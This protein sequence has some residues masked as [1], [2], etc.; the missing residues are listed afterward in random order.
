[1]ETDNIE[2]IK[3]GGVG[4]IPT[5]TVYGLAC[6]AFNESAL[7]RM[8]EI[9]GRAENKPPVVLI[10]EMK[11]L[12]KFG[13]ELSDRAKILVT[14]FWPGPVSI[15][16]PIKKELAYLDKG[17]GLAIRLP[18]NSQLRD[19]LKKTGP[20]ATTSANLQGQPPA[21]NIEEARKYFG[22]RV[23]FYKEG[24]DLSQTASTLVKVKGDKVEILRQGTLRIDSNF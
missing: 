5:D 1:M 9:K 18:D 21:K 15:I 3:N 10:A 4:V 11:D 20:L 16:L 24:C 19:F 7:E 23:D 12:E 2:I 22:R 17:L 8:F 6:S 14:K 13:A